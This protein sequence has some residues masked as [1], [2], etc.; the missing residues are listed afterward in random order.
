MFKVEQQDGITRGNQ[1]TEGPMQ[2][3]DYKAVVKDVVGRD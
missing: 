2:A 3:E 1:R